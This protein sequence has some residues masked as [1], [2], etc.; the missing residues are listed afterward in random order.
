MAETVRYEIEAGI[1]RIT[2]IAGESGNA[3]NADSLTALSRAL[4]RAE[5]DPGCRA[6]VLCAEGADFC[7]GLDLTAVL[8]DPTAIDPKIFRSFV[9]CLTII[10]HSPRPV[11][12]GICGSVKGGGVGLAAAC[13]LVIAAETATFMLPEVII[14]MIPALIA[15]FLLRRL[16]LAQI[17]YLTLSSRSLDAQEAKALGLVD[18]VAASGLQAVLEKQIRRILRSSPL[19]LAQSKRYFELLDPQ[20]LNCNT[21]VALAQLEF[22]VKQP[23][24]LDGLRAFAEGFSPSWF[25]KIGNQA[26]AS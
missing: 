17:R 15:P 7:S 10:C 1:A 20:D 19:A 12:A 11:I 8:A 9:D 5:G 3:L 6:I 14:G 18:E 25:V 26:T 4:A 24:V 13:D 2:L 22:W 16:T 23:E 21:A